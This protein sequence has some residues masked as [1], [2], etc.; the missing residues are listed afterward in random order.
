[1]G[2]LPNGSCELAPPFICTNDILNP[3]P[4]SPIVGSIDNPLVKNFVT[5]GAFASG[6]IYVRDAD[7]SRTTNRA[8]LFVPVRGDPSITYLDVNDDSDPAHV[9]HACSGDFCLECAEEG[10]DRR[11][12]NSH[13][14][15]ED[16]FDNTRVLT[17]PT[18]PVGIAASQD[19]S[20]LV[21]AHDTQ[22][23]V[24]LSSNS[25]VTSP[26]LQFILTGLPTGPDEVATVPVPAYVTALRAKQAQNPNADLPNFDYQPGFLVTYRA[27]PTLDLIRYSSDADSMPPRP[28]LTRV[29][30]FPVVANQ[31]G[32]DS[33]G[34]AIDA[35]DRQACEAGCPGRGS[36]PNQCLLD[37]VA[38]NNLLFFIANR[39]PASLLLGLIKTEL[40]LSDDQGGGKPQVTSALDNAFIYDSIPLDTGPSHV[41]IGNIINQD[42]QLERRVFIVCFDTRF[43][44]MYDPTAQRVQGPFRT[45][46]GPQALAF[47]TA[48]DAS[49]SF[50]FVGHFTDSYLGVIDLDMRNPTFGTMFATIGEPLPPRES[51]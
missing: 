38:N 46:R 3:G 16:P 26:A 8:R 50:L 32:K 36:E 12:A 4:C 44:F 49:H 47:D 19:G 20:A 31:D 10:S 13:K 1:V 33:R 45:G 23:S 22:Q 43:V 24:S 18:E 41:E 17:L 11:C 27:T 42:G 9:G 5:I 2:V 6:A 40:T 29:N 7:P 48:P 30:T 28:F 25:W 21:V 35:S 37:C 34:V 39:A 15:G 14:I 51:R